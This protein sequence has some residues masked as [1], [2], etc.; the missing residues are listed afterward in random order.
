MK[1]LRVLAYLVYLPTLLG[2]FL[3]SGSKYAWVSETD[4]VLPA[5]A[6]ADGSGDR[7]LFKLLLLTI[8]VVSQAMLLLRTR[9]RKEK[10]VAFVL[11]LLALIVWGLTR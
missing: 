6:I 11:V 7:A 10:I 1:L 3:L 5:S 4:P 2:L 8:V 9:S